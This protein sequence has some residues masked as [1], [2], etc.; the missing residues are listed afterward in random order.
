M[1]DDLPFE[2]SAEIE[3]IFRRSED[4]LFVVAGEVALFRI[5]AMEADPMGELPGFGLTS[6]GHAAQRGGI[7]VGGSQ[8]NVLTLPTGF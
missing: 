8:E 7:A 2:F 4:E 1:K 5:S 3:G 6:H